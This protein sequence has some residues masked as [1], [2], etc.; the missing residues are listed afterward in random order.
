MFKLRVGVSGM[1]DAA[2]SIVNETLGHIDDIANSDLYF[3]TNVSIYLYPSVKLWMF[4]IGD[5]EW[6][7]TSLPIP[8]ILL[9]IDRSREHTEN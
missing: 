4:L 9:P 2:S 3:P 1:V 8:R 6:R 5:G 7:K